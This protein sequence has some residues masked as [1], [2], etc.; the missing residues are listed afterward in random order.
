MSFLLEQYLSVPIGTIEV[1]IGTLDNFI[2]NLWTLFGGFLSWEL[3]LNLSWTYIPDRI[4]Y[5]LIIKFLK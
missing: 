5:N 2:Q 4:H 3:F 1:L